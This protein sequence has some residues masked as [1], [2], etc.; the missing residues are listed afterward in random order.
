MKCDAGAK[1]QE[2][3]DLALI[4]GLGICP[5]LSTPPKIKIWKN[6]WR[7]NPKGLRT[8]SRYEKEEEPWKVPWFVIWGDWESTVVEMFRLTFLKTKLPLGNKS[9]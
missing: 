2:G 3:G 1:I 8:G 9:K 6:L 7:W 5:N 4:C